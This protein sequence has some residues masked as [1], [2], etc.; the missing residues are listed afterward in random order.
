MLLFLLLFCAAAAAATASFC[1]IVAHFVVFGVA[2]CCC[3][4]AFLFFGTVPIALL[5]CHP[6]AGVALPIFGVAC[7]CCSIARLFFGIV[8]VAL[9]L[10]C[11][12]AGVALP[13]FDVAYCW[14]IGLA[15]TIYIYTVYIRC[16][17]QENH[18]L[19]GHVRGIYTVLVN[20]T[21]VAF[22]FCLVASCCSAALS[23]FG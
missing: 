17:W 12:L 21:V 20:S 6:L 1:D 15:R 3:S 14:C 11:L 13:I 8:P 18:Q 23:P 5:L 19:Y 16:F 2:C 10:C 22:L 4:I 9:L 7:C